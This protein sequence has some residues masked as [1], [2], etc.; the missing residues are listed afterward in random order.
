MDILFILAILFAGILLF[1]WILANRLPN[2]WRIDKAVL[3]RASPRRIFS[4][5][6][7]LENWAQWTVWNPQNEPSLTFTYEGGQVGVG[8][9]Q[10]WKS[11][12]LNGKLKIT[13][14]SLDSE[15]QYEFQLSQAGLC[16]KGTLVLG[17]ADTLYTQV[18]WRC[19]LEDLSK[20]INPI[21]KYL[22][23]ALQ[24]SFD[25]DMEESLNNLV[26]LFGQD[27]DES[28]PDAGAEEA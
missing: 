19:E 6:D 8:A 24:K 4:L 7:T 27:T 20:S 16:I 14:I 3:V 10:I 21:Q 26:A 5:L 13:K 28:N 1:A 18:A 17:V 22:G 11:N 25:T 9:T 2:T 23:Y 15:L 12:R